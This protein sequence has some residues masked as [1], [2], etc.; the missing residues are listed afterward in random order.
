VGIPRCLDLDQGG[1]TPKTLKRVTPAEKAATTRRWDKRVREQ[2]HKWFTV[3]ER[4]SPTA[5]SIYQ[6]YDGDASILIDLPEC[7]E[8][9]AWCKNHEI[10]VKYVHSTRS[11]MGRSCWYW[12]IPKDDSQAALIRLK[13]LGSDFNPGGNPRSNDNKKPRAA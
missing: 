11:G 10:C 8:F 7:C 9:F 6:G 12:I 1:Q 4:K 2:S 3:I 5:S 13:W